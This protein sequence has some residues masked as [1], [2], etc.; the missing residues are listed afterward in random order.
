MDN[1]YVPPS[2]EIFEEIKKKSIGIWK[3]YDDT[4][5]Y[6]TEKI[7]RIKDLENVQDNAMY[8]VAMFDWV[9]KKKLNDKLSEESKAFIEN[10]LDC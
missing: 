1:Y 10:R 3:T 9:N 4:H 2:N 6:S 8:M 5:G 7:D